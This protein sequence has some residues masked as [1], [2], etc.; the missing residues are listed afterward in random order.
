MAFLCTIVA[1]PYEDDWNILKRVLQY[2]RGKIYLFLTLG[3]DEIT[4]MKLWVDVLYGIH[5]DCKIHT[6]GA[7]SLGWGVIL[8]KCQK[9]KL[10][11]KSSTEAEIVG[12]SD[13]LLNVIWARMFLEAQ[14]F[15]I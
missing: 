4:K 13:Y 2:L 10:N 9:Q 14:G 12:V 7:M 1:E 15:T 8:S 11:M 5:S 6:G 3:A